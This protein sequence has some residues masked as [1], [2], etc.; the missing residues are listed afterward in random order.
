MVVLVEDLSERVL[1]D[2][3]IYVCHISIHTF[4][5]RQISFT[6]EVTP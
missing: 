3:C 6:P 4:S 5:A 1:I 2:T